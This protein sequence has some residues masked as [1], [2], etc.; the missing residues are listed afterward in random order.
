MGEERAAVL[1]QMAGVWKSC[2]EVKAV[3]EEDPAKVSGRPRLP[4]YKHRTEGLCVLIYI[5]QALQG[6]QSKKRQ[7][8]NDEIEYTFSEIPGFSLCAR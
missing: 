4:R 1:K 6:G 3:Y 8:S 2:R 7:L 5:L